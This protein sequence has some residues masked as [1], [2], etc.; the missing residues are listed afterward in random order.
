MLDKIGWIGIQLTNGEVTF[1]ITVEEF[2]YFWKRIC[3]GISSFYLGI[4]FGHYKV[5]SHSD[6]LSGF[7]TKKKI[8]RTGCL[9]ECYCH[10]L[11]MILEKIAGV[12]PVNKLQVT[13]KL[14]TRKI[15]EKIHHS[16]AI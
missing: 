10:G 8:L 11:T 3:K 7:L 6:R 14:Q 2:Q 12:V 13:K 4:H 1:D 15:T 9:P 5:V 16:I